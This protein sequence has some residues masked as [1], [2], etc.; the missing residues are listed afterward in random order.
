M[1]LMPFGCIDWKGGKLKRIL[2]I[3][4]LSV[5]ILAPFNNSASA[6][7]V[8]ISGSSQ[9]E[10]RLLVKYMKKQGYFYIGLSDT[11]LNTFGAKDAEII[12]TNADDI[13]VG[14]G[15]ADN[16]GNFHI[17]VPIEDVYK[18]VVRFHGKEVVQVVKF[19]GIKDIMVYLGYFDSDIIDRWWL[20]TASLSN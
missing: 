3:F 11:D 10:S 15:L 14:T 9:F 12:I 1:R 7:D 8:F 4:W 20:R 18:V 5:L 2:L 19:P 13:A 16:K 6:S 17:T